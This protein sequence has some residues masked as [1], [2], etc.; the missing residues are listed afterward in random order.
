MTT[1]VTPSETQAVNGDNRRPDGR[2][3]AGNSVGKKFKSGE[4]GNI[5]GRP[6]GVR[7]V[8]E[9]FRFWLASANDKDP[10]STNADEI[11]RIVGVA[12]LSGDLKAV[13]LLLTRTEGKIK[14]ELYSFREP[15]D[16][17]KRERNVYRKM[18][19]EGVDYAEA[20]D[21]LVEEA[22]DAMKEAEKARRAETRAE[23]ARIKAQLAERLEKERV[24]AEARQKAEE[25]AAY[26]A[27]AGRVE[28]IPATKEEVARIAQP[29]IETITP[30]KA[31]PPPP[32]SSWGRPEPI[33]F[34]P[35]QPAGWNKW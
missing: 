24:A 34:T 27:A 16:R 18:E 22:L 10:A 9:A 29:P 12:A 30:K 31:D 13:E 1:T 25:A 8:S 28:S 11:A 14:D 3:A 33:P 20:F 32:A 26:K 2:F 19:L 5:R 23:A 4:S 7:Y 6:R 15:D 21:M 35:P 17:Y